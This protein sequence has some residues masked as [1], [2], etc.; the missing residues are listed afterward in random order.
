[1]RDIYPETYE[2]HPTARPGGA[3]PIA[4]LVRASNSCCNCAISSLPNRPC[5]QSN[6]TPRS[7]DLDILARC[8]AGTGNQL[9]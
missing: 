7:F 4:S 8:G 5:G 2:L 1:M 9:C 6:V 3:G